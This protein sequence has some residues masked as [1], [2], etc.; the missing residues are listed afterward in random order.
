MLPKRTFLMLAQVYDS[1]KHNLEGYYYSE[2]LDG[3][4]VFWDGGIS[5][6]LLADEVPY[7]NT[8]KDFRR[9]AQIRSTGLWSRYGKTIQAHSSFLD[10]LPLGVCLDGELFIDRGQFQRT[11]SITKNYSAMKSEWDSIRFMIF[12]SPSYEAFAMQGR[13]RETHQELDFDGGIR[14]WIRERG[15]VSACGPMPDFAYIQKWMHERVEEN[16]SVRLVENLLVDR[17]NWKNFYERIVDEGGEGV[18]LRAG[19]S[20]WRAQRCNDLLKVKPSCNAICEIVGWSSG[21]LTD[22]DSRWLGMIGALLVRWDG[23]VFGLS[24][25]NESERGLLSDWADW[26]IEHPGKIHPDGDGMK[27]FSLGQKIPFRY[28]E[29]TRDGIP[30][31]ATYSRGKTNN[32]EDI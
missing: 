2:K 32:V 12:D 4:R 11:V 20:N 30:K 21:R 19:W 23:Q 24:G 27:Q 31:E 1:K 28:R 13:V 18:I 5:R 25:L 8:T 3:V 16:E 15:G 14:D 22:K 9:L 17:D 7:A 6:G 26:A 10:R 29:L